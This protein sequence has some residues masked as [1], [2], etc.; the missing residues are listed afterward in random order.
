MHARYH[1]TAHVSVGVFGNRAEHIVTQEGGGERRPHNGDIQKAHSSPD[2]VRDMK[3]KE[4]WA[5]HVA[6]IAEM[7]DSYSISVLKPKT[8]RPLGK[9]RHRWRIILKLIFKQCMRLWT[10]LSWLR[11]VSSGLLL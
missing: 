7:R 1:G 3:S 2:V 11:I 8:N 6:R 10:G 4:G 5:E 9:S